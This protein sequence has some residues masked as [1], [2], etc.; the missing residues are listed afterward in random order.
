MEGHISYY[1][2]RFN[3]ETDCVLH[4]PDGR[5]AL[6]EIKL[7]SQDIEKAA[8]HL[9][10]LKTL[11]KKAN[12][13]KKVNLTEPDLLIILTGGEFAYTRKDGVKIIP[14]GTLKN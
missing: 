3:L 8:A 10:K 13:E 6:I 1:R 9:I 4:L 11:I 5:Y 7:G 14:I 12:S 2:D